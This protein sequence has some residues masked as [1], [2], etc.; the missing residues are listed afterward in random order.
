L[1]ED[2]LSGVLKGPLILPIR[3]HTPKTQ[4]RRHYVAGDQR[5]KLKE[6]SMKRIIIS[7]PLLLTLALSGCQSATKSAPASTGSEADSA[8]TVTR[9]NFVRA[10]SDMQLRGYTKAF[11]LFGKF[12]QIT[13]RPNMDTIYSLA[14][15]DLTSPLTIEMPDTAGKYQSLMA[16]S[17]DHSITSYY[18]G[19]HTLTQE[20]IGTRYAFV[21]IRTFVD[22]ADKESLVVAHKL[23]DSVVVTQRGP[24]TFTVP[25]YDPASLK[26]TRESVNAEANLKPTTQGFFGDIKDLDPTLHLYG[27]AYGWGGLP[28]KD[29]IYVGRTVENPDGVTKYAVTAKEVPVDAFWSISVYD[30][31][32]YFVPNDTGVYVQNSLTSEKN[33]DGSVTVNFGNPDAINN[34]AISDGWNFLIRLYQPQESIL[35]S[36]WEFPAAVEVQ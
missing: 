6:I 33:A 30:K 15:F 20:G 8:I 14:V 34:I 5:I 36:E 28:E 31:D 18:E 23:Q 29:A 32:G 25:A 17:Q 22:P 26:T 11:D 16:V 27:A 7:I 21:V 3:H 10:E 19:T 24:G 1:S 9:E 35:N 2:Y 4:R 12:N 13:I